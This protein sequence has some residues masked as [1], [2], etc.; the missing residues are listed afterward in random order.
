MNGG[1]WLPVPAAISYAPRTLDPTN[2]FSKHN[3]KTRL[4]MREESPRVLR[5]NSTSTV[6]LKRNQSLSACVGSTR[7][8]KETALSH[9]L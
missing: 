8:P 4:E 1:V 9:Y 6:F 3:R 5:L 7:N 2:P